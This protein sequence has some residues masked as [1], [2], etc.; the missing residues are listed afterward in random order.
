MVYEDLTPLTRGE[1]EPL[2]AQALSSDE[3]SAV[4]LRLSLAPDESAWKQRLFGDIL[5]G[6]DEALHVAAALALGHLAR[7]SGQIDRERALAALLPLVGRPGV[8]G[9]AQDAIDDI[10]IF[11]PE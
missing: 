9:V 10:G 4:L 1:G 5:R 11:C 8:G 6:P 3:R 2:L 7:V